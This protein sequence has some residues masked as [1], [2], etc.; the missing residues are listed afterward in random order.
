MGCPSLTIA[1]P[2][3]TCNAFPLHQR[4]FPRC[5]RAL[6]HPPALRATRRLLHGGISGYP[7]TAVWDSDPNGN[8]A[9]AIADDAA[10]GS[11]EAGRSNSSAASNGGVGTA[12]GDPVT[13]ATTSNS[14][15]INRRPRRPRVDV[16]APDVR[17]FK[18]LLQRMQQAVL[19]DSGVDAGKMVYSRPSLFTLW[20]HPH[21]SFSTRNSHTSEPVFLLI[22]PPP[23]LPSSSPPGLQQTTIIGAFS[24]LAPPLHPFPPPPRQG[25]SSTLPAGWSGTCPTTSDFACNN[26]KIIGGGIFHAGFGD[27]LN[28]TLD[29]LS[30]RDSHG[31]G[32]WCAGLN[33]T[34]D[35]LSPRDSYGHGTWCAG[36]AAGNSGV[37]V[38]GGG[39]ISGVAPKARLAIYKVFWHIDERYTGTGDADVFAA[40]DQAVADGVDVLTLSLNDMSRSIATNGN[41]TF[42]DDLPFLGALA[43]G[44]RG[45][46]WV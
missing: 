17:A 21:A 35:W 13:A 4:R 5:L 23:P 14:G 7:A 20:A 34:L 45:V 25:Y 41:R 44:V 30:P 12:S 31:H 16:R 26:K 10:N 38:P 43:V 8:T 6:H 46:Q 2:H 18:Q 24:N 28:L 1:P 15:G 3:S 40:V 19:R 39:T 32:T 11:D 33:L 22:H 29:W 27:N 42:F 9:D 36:A 37:E